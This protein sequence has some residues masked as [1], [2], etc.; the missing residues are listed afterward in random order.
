MLISTEPP[1]QVTEDLAKLQELKILIDYDDNGYLLQIFTK[2]VQDRPT[3]FIEVIQRH[4]HQG[5]N[6]GLLPIVNVLILIPA[7][8][9]ELATSKLCSS[10]LSWTR[11]REATCN[12]YL[13]FF[14]LTSGLL[15]QIFDQITYFRR[16]SQKL[17]YC[18]I[19][20]CIFNKHVI[21]F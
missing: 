15:Y 14:L 18:I 13:L 8:V 21:L 11:Q 3:V 7:Q 16:T 10:A 1:V 12:L 6:Q 17:K 20:F 4:N 5:G 19:Y 2:P 9:L